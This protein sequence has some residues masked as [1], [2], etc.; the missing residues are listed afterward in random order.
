[1]TVDAA[2]FIHE[3]P[4]TFLCFSTQGCLITFGIAVIRSIIRHQRRLVHHNCQSPVQ[5]KIRFHVGV[6]I[7]GQLLAIPPFRLERLSNQCCIAGCVLIQPATTCVTV[8]PQHTVVL[9]HL[10]L[11]QRTQ[12][13]QFPPQLSKRTTGPR[14]F[15]RAVRRS[16]G[17]RCEAGVVNQYLHRTHRAIRIRLQHS[18]GRIQLT[19]RIHTVE[20]TSGTAIPERAIKE[21]R[22]HGRRSI[23][24]GR[25]P[26]RYACNLRNS[27]RSILAIIPRTAGVVPRVTSVQHT[28][29][30]RHF[31]R[32]T[33]HR[34]AVQTGR[35]RRILH[36]M[37]R[38]VV[39][40]Q[41][42]IRTTKMLHG[43]HTENR[44][45]TGLMAECTARGSGMQTIHRANVR[46]GI[47]MT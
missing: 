44:A 27:V 43:R 8:Q 3:N 12:P 6:A 24:T 26:D 5:R 13:Q 19:Q 35:L 2:T 20:V 46:P 28:L 32:I 14:H 45:S 15:H 36:P 17:L 37:E 9:G 23:S 16:R 1:M 30:T 31:H 25:L 22:V 40:C 33:S 11:R 38:E 42:L 4:Q 29:R 34:V 10:L 7:G 39:A 47:P 18:R 21:N 41:Q